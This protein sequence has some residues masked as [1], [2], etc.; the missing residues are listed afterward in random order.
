MKK[1][2]TIPIIPA[3]RTET[4][5]PGVLNQVLQLNVLQLP[6][7]LRLSNGKQV[8][9]LVCGIK[10]NVIDGMLVHGRPFVAATHKI[11][12]LYGTL[13]GF[14]NTIMAINL[15]TLEPELISI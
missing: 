13:K 14:Y 3:H 10:I 2:I 11:I 7:V 1:Q 12:G 4:A 15:Q 9:K 5:L 8:A 6:F